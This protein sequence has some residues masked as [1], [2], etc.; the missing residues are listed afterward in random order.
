MHELSLARAVVAEVS[1]AAEAR[2][3][4]KVIEVELKIGTLCGVIAE[5]LVFAF[6]MASLG[7]RLEGAILQ[8]TSSDVS[9]WCE[10]CDAVVEPSAR[11]VFVCPECN[12]PCP[13]L[14]S[15]RELEIVRFSVDPREVAATW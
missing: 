5:S 2:S 10:K 12:S 14:R 11:L 6:E 13:E 9:V 8:I 15:G 7:T 4:E 3:F 1:D